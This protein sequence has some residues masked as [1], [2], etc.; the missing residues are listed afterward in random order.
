MRD[1]PAV[2]PPPD[3]DASDADHR[4]SSA[5]ATGEIILEELRIRQVS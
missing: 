1:A 4:L 2:L 3:C 5:T